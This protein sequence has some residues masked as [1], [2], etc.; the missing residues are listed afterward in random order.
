MKSVH[1]LAGCAAVALA[2]VL[3]P[4][5]RSATQ[6]TAEGN[7]APNFAET[8]AKTTTDTEEVIVSGRLDKLSSVVKAIA[9]AEDRFLNRYND[10]NDNWQYDVTCLVEA[11]TGRRI[12]MR[13]CE[14]GYVAEAKRQDA[15]YGL[16]QYGNLGW[17]PL[18]EST[19]VQSHLK[20]FQAKM[21]QIVENDVELQRA[22]VERSLL[23]ER[24]E[25]IRKKKFEEQWIVWD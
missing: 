1:S 21:R 2:F 10:L 22:L 8:V 7:P 16:L 6:G 13:R 24:Y 14:T 25:K 9:T 12:T 19:I 3:A 18:P 11:P 23:I 20:E 4:M 17:S 15:V 5:A